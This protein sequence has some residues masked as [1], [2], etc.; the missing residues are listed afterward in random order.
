MLFDIRTI[1]GSLL[2]IYGVVLII[3]A[4]VNDTAAQEAKTGGWNVNLWAGLGMAAVAVAFIAWVLLRPVKLP[5]EASTAEPEPPLD[6][7][8]APADR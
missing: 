1:V 6:P 8:G 5:A 3:T 7:E 4:L 2:G